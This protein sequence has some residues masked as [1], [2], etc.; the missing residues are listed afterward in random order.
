MFAAGY[1]LQRVLL[2]RLLLR[3]AEPVL[4]ATFGLML[5][6]HSIFTHAF[7]G[8][9]KS[10]EASYGSSG[11]TVLGLRLRVSDLIGFAL[12]AAMV[13]FVAGLVRYTSFGTALRAAAVDPVT[14]T[15]V[16]IDVRHVYATTF[17]L[18][19]ALA[20]VA[21]VVIGIGFS[22]TPTS[23]LLY[24]TIGFT[25]VVLGGLGSVTGTFGAAIVVGLAQALGGEVFG[26]SYQNL[27]VYLLFVL[28]I[29]LRPQGLF[30]RSR[31]A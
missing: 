18:A 2:T 17:G 28:L 27:T 19:T 3:G 15:S 20:A 10:L 12:A 25:V 7:T 9:P 6:G 1:A 24:L 30:A 26:P 23:G 13:A 31:L 22:F 4:V 8:N 14:A 29:G 11:V 5:L 16:G 21:G